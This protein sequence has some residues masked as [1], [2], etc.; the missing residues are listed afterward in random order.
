MKLRIK[1]PSSFKQIW[2]FICQS[3]EDDFEQCLAYSLNTTDDDTYFENIYDPQLSQIGI[4]TI[5]NKKIDYANFNQLP[6]EKMNNRIIYDC[7]H[8]ILAYIYFYSEN[9]LNIEELEFHFSGSNNT[10]QNNILNIF[11]YNDINL[12]FQIGSFRQAFFGITF[13]RI[14][15]K[16]IA[17]SIRSGLL[18]NTSSHLVSFTFEGFDIINNQWDLLDERA[19]INDLIPS[20]GYNM[21]FV[22]STDK[23]YSSFK[24]VQQEPGN[25][26][27]WGF[28][29]AAFDVHGIIY[30]NDESSAQ[31]DENIIKNEDISADFNY[32]PLMDMSD[33]LI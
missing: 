27:F 31:L 32:N 30:M 15:I 23:C 10:Q 1:N 25:N 18:S 11:D 22:R 6:P 5:C 28:S 26:G 17:Y 19:N 13:K 4:Q 8:G 29:I 14:K 2:S 12:Q 20:G 9:K 24:I 21:F 3:K 7:F 33:F 16:P